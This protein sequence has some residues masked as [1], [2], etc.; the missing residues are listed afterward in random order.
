MGKMVFR[1]MVFYVN[2]CPMG[3][4]KKFNNIMNKYLYIFLL[5]TVAL[6][7]SACDKIEKPYMTANN[8]VDTAECP[9]P[10]FPSLSNIKRKIML[11]EFTGH[12]CPNCPTGAAIASTLLTTYGSQLAVVAIHA[13]YFATA[14]ASGDF[15]ANFSTPEG[16]ELATNFSVTANPIGMVNRTKYNSSTL[17]NTGDWNTAISNIINQPAKMYLQTIS[18]MKGIDSSFCIF[19]KVNFLASMQ[20]EYNLCVFITEDSIVAP[21]ATNDV[22]NYPS[23][24]ISDYRHNHVLRKVLGGT[25]GKNIANGQVYADSSKVQ[26][27]KLIP[28]TDWKLSHCEIVSFVYN[29]DTQE[30][31]QVDKIPLLGN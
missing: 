9:T 28:L 12:K 17:I 23:G 26:S 8:N 21:Q 11:E 10:T 18:Q 22:T 20:G 3:N 19:T 25:W 6:L 1:K 2:K 14:D 30:I 5:G 4:Y 24:V 27:Y 29:T 16:E 13:G 15:T 7:F 31:V